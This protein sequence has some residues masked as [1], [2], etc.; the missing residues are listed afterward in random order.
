M[1]AIRMRVVAVLA[2]LLLGA[3]SS[4]GALSKASLFEPE[5]AGQDFAVGV[6]SYEGGDYDLAITMLQRAFQEGLSVKDDQLTAYKYLAFSYCVTDREKL[7][8]DSFKKA[9]DLDPN[10]DLKPAE[11]GHPIWGPVFRSVKG[12]SSS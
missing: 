2:S 4:T 5:N 8:R 11:A 10:F 6:R 7:C 12:K 9:L 1:L 3:C